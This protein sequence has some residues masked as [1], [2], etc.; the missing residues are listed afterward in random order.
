MLSPV[1]YRCPD[2]SILDRS[3]VVVDENVV[4]GRPLSAA[5]LEDLRNKKR[6]EPEVVTWGRCQ[7]DLKPRIKAFPREHITF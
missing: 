4:Y 5:E 1:S 6:A 3:Y 7:K 2:S